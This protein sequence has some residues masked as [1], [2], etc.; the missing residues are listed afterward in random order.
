MIP[1]Y[2]ISILSDYHLEDI[3]RHQLFKQLTR[4]LK[5]IRQSL[6]R[7]SSN[8]IELKLKYKREGREK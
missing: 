7:M 4:R 1:T 6:K 2:S 8:E 3:P 5:H